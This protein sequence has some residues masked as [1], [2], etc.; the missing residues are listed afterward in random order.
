[1]KKDVR[2]EKL[3]GEKVVIVD[4]E[5]PHYQEVG[6]AVKFTQTA[7]GDFG[8]IIKLEND[9]IECFVFDKKQVKK[10]ISDDGEHQDWTEEEI[11]E[12]L[13]ACNYVPSQIAVYLDKDVQKFL[14]EFQNPTSEV[15]L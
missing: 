6:K 5:H 10:L 1:M 7:V 2:L 3:L 4:P 13:A 8:L 12:Q 14:Q 15:Y 11:I 9:F